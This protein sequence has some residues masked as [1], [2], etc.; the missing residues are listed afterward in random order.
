MELNTT[1]K[2]D[3]YQEQAV[4]NNCMPG[5]DWSILTLSNN[6]STASSQAREECAG[7]SFASP[8]VFR[9][10]KDCGLS[11]RHIHPYVKQFFSGQ[12]FTQTIKIK[13]GR[14]PKRVTLRLGG[15]YTT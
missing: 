14:S 1:F 3:S 2:T 8:F 9:D 11:G 13:S 10:Q 12:A 15:S 7:K 5:E 4:Q 6:R